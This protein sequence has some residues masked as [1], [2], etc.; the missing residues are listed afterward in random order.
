MLI[1]FKKDFINNLLT[2]RYVDHINRLNA[3]LEKD[4][5]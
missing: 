3:I 4:R 1:F 2:F 5:W